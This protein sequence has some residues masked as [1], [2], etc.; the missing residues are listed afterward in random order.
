LREQQQQALTAPPLCRE[1]PLKVKS[2]NGTVQIPQ[3]RRLADRP[4][5]LSLR[6]ANAARTRS[7]SFT[8]RSNTDNAS[9][10]TSACARVPCSM[11]EMSQSKATVAPE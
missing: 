7:P 5:P 11:I 9:T 1:H 2:H 6:F 4:T 8:L 10:A 3:L